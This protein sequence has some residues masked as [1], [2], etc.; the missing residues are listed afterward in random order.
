MN[1]QYKNSIGEVQT[2]TGFV[3][4]RLDSAVKIWRINDNIR[5]LHIYQMIALDLMDLEDYGGLLI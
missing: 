1:Y 2:A 4:L 3:L 5:R